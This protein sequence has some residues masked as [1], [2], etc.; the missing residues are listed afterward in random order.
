M[1][2]KSECPHCRNHLTPR[3]LVNCRFAAD[4]SEAIDDLDINNARAD[5]EN[6]QEHNTELNYYCKTCEIPICSD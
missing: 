4:I 1:E 2:R 3:Q 6:C 5:D